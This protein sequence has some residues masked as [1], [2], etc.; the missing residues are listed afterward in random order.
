M[1]VLIVVFIKIIFCSSFKLNKINNF[2]KKKIYIYI[3]NLSNYSC[4]YKLYK[5]K[6]VVNK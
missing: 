1:I 4:F 5:F 6:Y 3:F 2:K